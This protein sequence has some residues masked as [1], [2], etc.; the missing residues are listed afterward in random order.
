MSDSHASDDPVHAASQS[1]TEHETLAYQVVASRRAQFDSAVWATPSLSI[2]AQSFVLGIALS[3]QVP[4]PLRLLA[5]AL[6]FFTGIAAIALMRRHRL[7]ELADAS[8]LSTFERDHGLPIIHGEQWLKSETEPR[9]NMP[10]WWR[11][12]SGF[13]VYHLW[14]TVLT[15]Y[16]IGALIAWGWTLTTAFL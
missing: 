11:H 16:A 1:P 4:P 6:G 3:N 12:V 8:W 13:R 10:S 7:A 9:W 15:L 2:A 5:A 14:V